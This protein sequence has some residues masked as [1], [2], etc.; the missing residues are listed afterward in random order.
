MGTPIEDFMDTAASLVA[1]AGP[2]PQTYQAIGALLADLAA[3][4]PLLTDARLG[5]LHGS[6]A[7]ANVVGRHPSGPVLMLSRFP[8]HAPTPVHNHNSWGVVYVLAGRD[9]YQ[10]WVREDDASDPSHADVHLAEERTLAPGDVVW[11]DGPPHDLHAQQGLGDDAWELVFFGHDPDARPRA[12]VD[13]STGVVT[14]RS[15]V[16]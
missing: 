16:R 7:A 11:F 3:R 10:R 1:R 14:Y 6:G 5:D 2:G 15:A 9:V 12:Y 4:A 8:A 13:P